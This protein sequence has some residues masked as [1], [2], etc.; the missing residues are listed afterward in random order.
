[1]IRLIERYW[2]YDGI[3]GFEHDRLRSQLETFLAAPHYGRGWL[4][5]SR[6]RIV[7]YLLA[8]FTYSFEHGGLMAEI[9]EI[10]VEVDQRGEG[11]GWQLFETAAESL[12]QSGCVAL[13][14]QVSA[15]NTVAQRFYRRCG[16]EPKRGFEVWVAALTGL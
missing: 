7:A 6:G 1:M 5:E 14:M 13:Q 9:D 16:L 11:L 2:A 8:T 15:A 4:A 3:T 12:R 10:F